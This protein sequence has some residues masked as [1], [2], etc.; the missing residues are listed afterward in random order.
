MREKVCGRSGL[1]R[2]LEV[3]ENTTRNWE[4]KGLISPECFVDGRPLFS[5]DKARQLKQA[6]DSEKVA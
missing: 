5:E 1:A 3:S 2:I 6:K 4:I